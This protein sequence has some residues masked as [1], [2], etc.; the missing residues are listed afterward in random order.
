MSRWALAVFILIA[1]VL[2][3]TPPEAFAQGVPFCRPGQTPGFFWDS[4]ASKLSLAR[5]WESR[6]SASTRTM[7]T[8]TRFRKRR[9][10]SL[11]GASQRTRR[12]S[13]T[14]TD[15]GLSPAPVSCPG[16]APLRIRRH[17]LFPSRHRPPR[18]RPGVSSRSCKQSLGRSISSGPMRFARAVSRT[19]ARRSAGS[20]EE[21]RPQP[22]EGR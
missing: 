20:R 8:A 12:L 17:W 22:A 1:S 7:R 5:L 9:R 14:E 11:T 18:H 15:T 16:L 6:S 3:T 13:P 4:P 10:V 19:R 21:V 2:L